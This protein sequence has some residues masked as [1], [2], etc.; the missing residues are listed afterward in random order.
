MQG[1]SLAAEGLVTS[2]G[3]TFPLTHDSLAEFLTYTSDWEVV[4]HEDA[5]Q[6]CAE[7]GEERMAYIH[8]CAARMKT[9]ANQPVAKIADAALISQVVGEEKTK[10]AEAFEDGYMKSADPATDEGPAEEAPT[11]PD[12]PS[13]M[14]G[15]P[16]GDWLE[17][18]DKPGKGSRGG[19]IVGH[20]SSGKPIY[21]SPGK[22]GTQRSSRYKGWESK[23]HHEAASH[24]KEKPRAAEYGTHDSQMLS[25][26][27]E[28]ASKGHDHPNAKEKADKAHKQAEE[29]YKAAKEAAA[30]HTER[31]EDDKAKE[32][33]T[34]AHRIATKMGNNAAAKRHAEGMGKSLSPL[35]DW[36]EKATGIG[37]IT[38]GGYRKVGRGKYV[39]VTGKGKDQVKFSKEKAKLA[40]GHTQRAIET[41]DKAEDAAGYHKASAAHA[42]AASS[43]RIAASTARK[44]E[45]S[46]GAH[47]HHTKAADVHDAEAKRFSKLA[48]RESAGESAGGNAEIN[49]ETDAIFSTHQKLANHAHSQ[50]E[51]AERRSHTIKAKGPSRKEAIAAQETARDAH[52][53]A[54]EVSGR[55]EHLDLAKE[56]QAEAG[57][58]G[59]L[60]Y[61]S[62]LSYFPKK[63]EKSMNNPLE[64]WLSKAGENM[65]SHE[66][67]FGSGEE[68]GKTEADGGV[69]AGKPAPTGPSDAGP[70][71]DAKAAGQPPSPSE[72][73]LSED[74]EEDEAQMK[75][76]KK[77]IET[78]KSLDWRG[79]GDGLAIEND[80]YGEATLAKSRYAAQ[81]AQDRS[82]TF[83]TVPQ[84]L[85]KSADPKE[86]DPVF[87]VQKGGGQVVYSDTTDRMIMKALNQ[88]DFYS[89]ESP[90]LGI[91]NT[92]QKSVVCKSC[93]HDTP[94]Y[95]ASC[96]TCGA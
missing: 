90:T 24:Y 36:L 11:V 30:S 32:A 89:F 49:A 68:S 61:F 20:T 93:K 64:D 54:H 72:Q 95:L 42:Q 14:S 25:F 9:F 76:H 2:S 4:D 41:Q 21:A 37:G 23:D 18:A 6:L 60:S 57:R 92:L 55:K 44:Y 51:R 3:K 94:V 75:E 66:P 19:H 31:G 85:V 34:E 43:H 10:I 26:H 48:T 87:T 58:L 1:I 5:A 74:D 50:S 28:A 81:V 45:G 71:D 7:S 16:M 91:Q 69:M 33:H 53:T 38:P 78:A 59:S 39:K 83:G 73:K 88:D 86:E 29:H 52:L 40:S 67:G 79:F 96:T 13:E 56:H 80:Y 65:P 12:R 47:E 35:G 70:V 84:D 15:N 63:T 46:S 62:S 8:G 27:Q 77:P 17:K 22:A 82:V